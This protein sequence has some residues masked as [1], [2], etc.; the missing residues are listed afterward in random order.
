MNEKDLLIENL[1]NSIEKLYKDIDNQRNHYNDEIFTIHQENNKKLLELKEIYD[2]KSENKLCCSIFSS[3]E[4]IEINN[5]AA[6]NN[7][8][9]IKEK[10]ESLA[11]DWKKKTDCIMNDFK[12]YVNDFNFLSSK[13]KAHCSKFFNCF[14]DGTLQKFSKMSKKIGKVKKMIVNIAQSPQNPEVFGF[15]SPNSTKKREL[16]QKN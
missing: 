16:S 15:L 10:L 6:L 9:E 5:F 4:N 8:K 3:I 14:T 13:E 7:V 12:C 2:K 11:K 1:K